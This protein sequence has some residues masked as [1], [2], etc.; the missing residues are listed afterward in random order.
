MKQHQSRR[1]LLTA[2]TAATAAAFLAGPA[3]GAEGGKKDK[4]RKRQSEQ[5]SAAPAGSRTL[6]FEL[7]L[8]SYTCRKFL[9]PQN[10]VGFS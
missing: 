2:A 5:A 1:E 3:L 6:P 9:W 4:G 8:A 10:P 7:G